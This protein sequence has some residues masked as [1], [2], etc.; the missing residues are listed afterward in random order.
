MKIEKENQSFNSSLSSNSECNALFHID[1]CLYNHY[2]RPYSESPS[3]ICPCWVSSDCYNYYQQ[4]SYSYLLLTPILWLNCA[5][6]PQLSID[7]KSSWRSNEV[8][9]YSICSSFYSSYNF[10]IHHFVDLATKN[11]YW[12]QSWALH[13]QSRILSIHLWILASS[14]RQFSTAKTPVFYRG[15]HWPHRF[16]SSTSHT[17]STHHFQTATANS[18]NMSKRIA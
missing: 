3:M 16:F 4:L 5:D 12:T 2:Y 7:L 14:T 10:E 1:F 8:R 11:S 9:H 13:W 15:N 17:S 6:N 18:V